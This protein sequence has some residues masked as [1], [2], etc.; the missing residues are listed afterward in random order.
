MENK[1]ELISD[2]YIAGFFD[3]EGCVTWVRS[4]PE[5]RT[6]SVTIVQKK[7]EILYLIQKKYGGKIYFKKDKSHCA[8]WRIC[9]VIDIRN[10]LSKIKP[11]CVVK[12]PDVII[13]LEY[14][15]NQIPCSM[16]F[17]GL[18]KEETEKR[19]SLYNKFQEEVRGKIPLEIK[20]YIGD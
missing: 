3:G 2:Q 18:S 7:P 1:V 16:R 15:N 4:R 17:R 10:F 8:Y 14:V 12:L 11:Y 19:Q 6:M 20:G 5:Y 9:R 13:A